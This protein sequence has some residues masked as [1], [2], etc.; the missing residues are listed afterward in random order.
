M[1]DELALSRIPSFAVA[2]SN[3]DDHTVGRQVVCIAVN[4]FAAAAP[5]M[6]EE[7]IIHD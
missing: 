4:V 6:V 2:P 3:V 7:L 5:N 1:N